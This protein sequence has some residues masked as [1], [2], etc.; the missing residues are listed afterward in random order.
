MFDN[1]ALY[2]I[3]HQSVGIERPEY[4]NLNQMMSQVVSSITATMRSSGELERDLGLLR[5]HLIHYPR[6]HFPLVSYAPVISSEK[7]H[8]DQSSLTEI[9]DACFEQTN[10]MM[11]CNAKAAKYCP[12]SVLYR[13]D[14]VLK[15]VQTARDTIKRDRSIKVLFIQL[16][17]SS[18]VI[19]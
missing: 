17:C 14:V 7:A 5:T 9:T 3:C 2:D 1:E 12:C 16:L 11:I 19:F 13:G 8:K 6:V 15:D 18:S 10:Q 4:K